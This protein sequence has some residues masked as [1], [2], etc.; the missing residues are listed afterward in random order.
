M[1]RVQ[2]ATI[3]EHDLGGGIDQQ[4]AENQ[5]QPGYCE[6]IENADPQ[7]TG[8]IKKRKGYQGYSGYLP[9]RVKEVDYDGTDINLIFDSSIE[10]PIGM[11]SPV[12]VKGKTSVA[13]GD[14]SAETILYFDGFT[15]DV[16]KTFATGSN[17]QTLTADEH[18]ISTPLLFSGVAI[19]NSTVNN[20]NTQFIPDSIVIDKTTYDIDIDYTNNSGADF[21]GFIYAKDKSAVSGTTYVQTGN[22]VSTGT[23]TFSITN[24]THGLDNN[25]IIVEVYKDTGTTYE[26]VQA[27]NVYLDDNTGDIDIELINNTGVSFTAVFI[28][29]AAPTAN[30]LTGSVAAGASQTITIDTS[31]DDGTDFAFVGCYLEPT[32]GGTLEQC[33]PDSIV[34]DSVNKTITVTFTNNNSTGANFEIYWDF[35]SI[36]TNKI[37]ITGTNSTTFTD[38]EPQLTVWGLSHDE[39]YG[40]FENREGW[41][42]HIDT[43]RA[44][45]ENRVISGLGGNLFASRLQDETGNADAY[46]MPTY[47]PRLNARLASDTIIGPAFYDSGETPNRTRGYITG[48][49]GGNNYFT[50]TS[51]AYNSGTGFVDYTLTI[52]SLTVNGIL[53][54]IIS[55]TSG[56]EDRLTAQQCGYSVHNGE[57]VIKGVTNPTSTTLV[58][59]VENSNIDSEDYDEL[60]VGG[61][62]G[63]FTDNI[64]L[65]ANSPFITSDIIDSDIFTDSDSYTCLN[66]VAA[67]TKL[68]NVVDTISLPGGLR[69]V[70]SRESYSI[71]LRDL[72]NAATVENIV[73]GD[74][75]EYSDINRQLRVKSINQLSDTSISIVGTGSEA[76]ITL[77]SG[78]TT[79]LFVG[80]KLLIA[81]TTSFNGDVEVTEIIDSTSFKIGSTISSSESGIIVGKTI[82]VDELLTFND[83]TN[84]SV[85]INVHS[86]WIPIEIPEDNF[87]ATP[88]T[89]VTHFDALGYDNQSILRSTMVQDNL[90]LTNSN[91]EV[92][93]FDGTNIYRAGLFR[94]QPHLFV[95]TDTTAAGKITMG[96]PSI[97]QADNATENYFELSPIDI[98]IFTVG[99]MVQDSTDGE[100]YTIKSIDLL[101]TPSHLH[102]SVDRK[103]SGGT[104]A[105]TLTRVRSFRYYFRLNAIDANDNRIASAVVGSDDF[106]VRLGEDAA[107]NIRLA[108]L[109]IFD[110]YDFDRLE[111]QIYR[112]KSDEL[113]PYYLVATLPMAFNST[114]GYLSYIDTA[115]DDELITEDAEIS[116]LKGSELGTAFNQPLRAKYCTTA[117]NRLVLGNVKD[118]PTIDLQIVK[119]T[120]TIALTQSIFTDADNKRW[121]FKKDNTDT[122]TTTDMVNRA[123]YE[124]V[125]AT[126]ALGA[127]TGAGYYVINSIATVDATSAKITT[128]IGHGLSVGDW[129]YL[130]NDDETDGDDV[131]AAGWF[132]VKIVDSGSEFTVSCEN[133][134]AFSL[135]SVSR[136]AVATAREDIPV[137]IGTDGNY[138]MFRGNLGTG[139]EY[140]F[141]AIKRLANAINCSMRKTDINISGYETFSPWMI[142]NAGNE[143]NSGQL[144]IR[145][146]RDFETFLELVIPTLSGD[147]D[148]FVNNVRRSGGDEVSSLTRV[149]PSRIIVSYKNYPEVF[150]NPTAVLGIDSDSFIDVNSADGQEITAIIPFFG[151]SAFGSAQKSGIVVVFKTNSIY[152]VDL[153]A[154]AAGTNAVQRLETRGKGCTA[155]YSVSVTRGGIMFANETGIY[156]LGRD[157]KVEY[158]GR[159]YERKFENEVNTDHLDIVTGHHDTSS[160]SYK[161]SYP[162]PGETENSKIAVYNHTREY[163]GR[164]EGSWS[165]YSNHNAVGWANLAAESLF[166]STRGRVFKIRNLGENSDFRD[167]DTA[168]AMEI[169]TR[170]MDIME[171]GKRKIFGKIITHYRTAGLSEGTS[172]NVALDLKSVFQDT[173]VFKIDGEVNETGL[174]DEGTKKVVTI[175]SV[176][177]EKVGVYI[178]LKYLNSSIDEPVEITGIDFRVAAKSDEG[179]TEARETTS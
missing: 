60:D 35:A 126:T 142:A 170:A 14:F 138:T 48:D 123:A 17:T 56:L 151:E 5:I 68:N 106:I 120:N 131:N 43:Y 6:D 166:A 84:F 9:V 64:T 112:T 149:F 128:S 98:N 51:I 29:T 122:L 32:I 154:K 52:P 83:T 24:A 168:I 160:N 140:R 117:D 65:T 26:R 91:D 40:T 163:E 150:D 125:D 177:D 159:K 41:V 55:T 80:K 110:T 101:D 176:F 175:T 21:Q 133:P 102:V 30:F 37:T 130:Y 95:T 143:Y 124:F 167:D 129:V 134:S 179:I 10:M 136:V 145:Q 104:A 108:G 62:G 81:E 161:L 173:D 8:H 33:I 137:L 44:P 54:T 118:Y 57:F 42:S 94:W 71:P 61:L 23:N 157:L 135:S 45:A 103:I 75:I 164:G 87:N 36:V 171:S 3:R 89:R 39:I 16:R 127:T 96:N 172:L 99:D 82:E 116:G 111:V 79:T 162:I 58:I 155:P 100:I 59:S 53:S 13:S 97:A 153:A 119:S 69:L 93:K 47:Y 114:D 139:E 28:L 72:N 70:G 113:A 88:K 1:A 146:P 169:L 76:T 46:L 144:I 27:S 38:T 67:V 148:V 15:A 2:Y 11:S 77:G 63:V 34:T 31:V 132:Q 178:Q 19:S 147:F 49:D 25:N 18:G 66:S 105:E 74:M 7:S 85:S 92:M 20:N 174:G 78:D 107:V 165:T 115:T 158:I 156:R 141:L 4:S 73:R 22:S 86:R 90:Y 109:P 152:L 50:I 12:I 121:L